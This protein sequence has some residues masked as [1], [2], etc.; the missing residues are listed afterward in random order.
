MLRGRA[1]VAM[2][3]L[4]AEIREVCPSGPVTSTALGAT[5]R[6]VP[7][8]LSTPFF[9]E[10]EIDAS[11][12][13][14]DDLPAALHGHAVVG[15]K[16]VELEPELVGAVDVRDD[17]GVFEERFRGDAAPIEAD[18][19]KGFSLDDAGFEAQLTGSDAGHIAA[20]PAANYRYVILRDG[21]HQSVRMGG[22]FEHN[23]P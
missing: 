19:A 17:L 13:A 8:M 4:R 15:V 1:P 14:V 21:G 12:H 11:G 22:L 3:M 16:V 6:A 2:M 23:A 10:E 20:G 9:A 18:T 7:E 5:I